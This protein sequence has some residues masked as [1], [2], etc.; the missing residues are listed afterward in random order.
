[1]RRLKQQLKDR[2]STLILEILA[3]SEIPSIKSTPVGGPH[4]RERPSLT[5]PKHCSQK[6]KSSR[7]QM[8]I[9][10]YIYIRCKMIIDESKIWDSL[11]WYS[12]MLQNLCQPHIAFE[13]SAKRLISRHQVRPR[14]E[15]QE[16]AY[17]ESR[18]RV[19][20][21]YVK[22]HSIEMLCRRRMVISSPLT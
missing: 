22:K 4:S 18:I 21:V 19:Q 8:W 12:N 1:M 13:L 20:Q 17:H 5:C 7:L 6:V 9:L 3:F 2:N 11:T 10:F 14:V 16:Q 15:D